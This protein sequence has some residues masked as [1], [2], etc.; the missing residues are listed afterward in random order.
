MIKQYNIKSRVTDLCRW[1]S[2]APSTYYYRPLQGKRGA[3]PS[4][5]TLRTDGSM[6]RNET[7][8][9]DIKVALNREFCCYGYHNITS[10]LR[11]MSYK[12]NHKKV[13]RLMDENNL[14]LG[15][16]IRTSGKRQ[17]VKHRKIEAA[18]PM[19]YLCLDIK[20]I[21]VAGEK[22]NYYLLTILDVYSRMAIEQIL[23]SSIKKIDVI[24]LFRR[25]NQRFSIK[26]V[27]VRNDNGSQFIANDVKRFLVSSEAKQEFTHIA[28]PQENSYIEA[29]HSIVQTE[30]VD[31]F[32]FLSYYEAK[33]TFRKH[34]QW[35]NNERKHGQ[36]GRITPQQKWN[37]HEINIFAS[38]GEAE[39]GNAG[40]Q[41]ARNSLMNGNDKEQVINQES[42]PYSY[43]SFLS[44]M[45]EKLNRK[46]RYQT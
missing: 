28:T 8:V 24:N 26:G 14:L 17:F 40:E 13:Y 7:V 44:N 45:P 4:T 27:T 31:R 10:D 1:M 23:Q 34:L 29:F 11:D 32:D 3:K 38:S 15:K 30:V 12:I 22:R 33:H 35:Y 25:I 18:Y 2:I 36:I 20:Y 6:V 43:Q 39:S 42:A 41:P 19:E 5:Y 37:T 16:V 21:W 9:E 46:K